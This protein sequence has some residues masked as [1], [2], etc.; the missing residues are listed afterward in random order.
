MSPLLAR[1]PRADAPL[2]LLLLG[3][4]A[5][6][7]VAWPDRPIDANGAWYAVA[8]GR[9]GG[10]MVLA[11]AAALSAGRASSARRREDLVAVSVAWA[12]SM[13]FEA[14]AWHGSSPN[15]S[16]AWSLLVAGPAALAAYGATA[17]VASV[18]R[19]L[20]LAWALPLLVPLAALGLGW[21]DVRTGPVLALPWL[22]PF[23]PSWTAVGVLGGAAVATVA[24]LS[25]PERAREA[26]S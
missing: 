16:L 1:S 3:L 21:I 4:A 7:G 18:A 23:A 13:P 9:H 10:L 19:R 20:R 22:L 5:T 6:L 14:L 2:A 11:A 15:A 12:L 8:V 17:V 26:G 24:R 25:W